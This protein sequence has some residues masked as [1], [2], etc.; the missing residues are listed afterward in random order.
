M[1]AASPSRLDFIGFLSLLRNYSASLCYD[2]PTTYLHQVLDPSPGAIIF[3]FGLES[4]MA[5]R[6]MR[7][8]CSCHRCQLCPQPPTPNPSSQMC[9]THPVLCAQSTSFPHSVK[10]QCKFRQ[11]KRSHV[12]SYKFS[13]KAAV[14]PYSNFHDK[15][16]WL[17]QSVST[18]I[19]SNESLCNLSVSAIVFV[20]QPSMTKNCRSLFCSSSEELVQHFP[21]RPLQ[22]S[23]LSP[24]PPVT[25][26]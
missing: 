13:W 24:P 7:L 16:P 8:P 18:V 2:T 6:H 21:L 26:D 9:H 1:R 20:L 17:L 25:S 22:S 15:A 14:L 11:G 19:V 12:F 5:L 10:P 3:E 4:A 23:P